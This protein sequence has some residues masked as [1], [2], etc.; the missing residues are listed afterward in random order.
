MK[1]Q[2]GFEAT[3]DTY[4]SMLSAYS[5]LGD[6]PKMSSLFREL[7][8]N[9]LYLGDEHM[10]RILITLARFGHD[11]HFAEVRFWI[12]YNDVMLCFIG[13]IYSLVEING[14]F[15]FLS[16]F[17]YVSINRNVPLRYP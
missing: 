2:C 16:V 17:F 12:I 14:W 10:H 7:E 1:D 13:I 6:W 4:G 11:G 3:A 5:R 8:Q 15:L 9:E